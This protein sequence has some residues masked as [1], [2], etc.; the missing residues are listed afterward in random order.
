MTIKKLFALSS[1]AFCLFTSVSHAGEKV[2]DVAKYPHFVKFLKTLNPTGRIFPTDPRNAQWISTP[3]AFVPTTDML[4][5][6][7][8]A[9]A[10]D[11]ITFFRA[12]VLLSQEI[13]K[14]GLVVWG[15]GSAFEQAVEKNKIDLG[16]A[17][18]VHD[19]GLAIWS[20][21]PS[22]TDPEFL[23]HLKLFYTQSYVHQ[24]PDEI[25]PAALKVG[26]GEEG[27][28]SF[29]DQEF[30]QRTVDADIYYGPTH[31]LGLRN[32]KGIGGQKRGWMGFMQ[33]VLFFLPDAIHSMTIDEKTDS[34]VTEA[35]INTVVKN[36]EST[37]AYAIKIRK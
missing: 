8:K 34:L 18:P 16:L 23:V 20:P 6:F 31:G 14:N 22:N 28:Y 25:L 11:H 10:A 19:I 5:G 37:P 17:L 30:T 7:F 15:P 27:T 36:F 1:V 33:K 32:I 13:K 21:D 35:L 29:D 12:I 26:L 3:Q 24:F 9:A 4:D 2:R